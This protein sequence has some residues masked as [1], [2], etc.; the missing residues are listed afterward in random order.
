MYNESSAEE[1]SGEEIEARKESTG[2][3]FDFLHRAFGEQFE[4]PRAVA[5]HLT[6]PEFSYGNFL[7]YLKRLN[8][9]VCDIPIQEREFNDDEMHV[10]AKTPFG[11]STELVTP[12][13]EAQSRLLK[14][15]FDLMQEIPNAGDQPAVIG[16]TFYNAIERIHP[17]GD[18]NGRT[19][20]ALFFLLCHPRY[21]SF[22]DLKQ[23][24]IEAISYKKPS[25]LNEYHKQLIIPLYVH[26][27]EKRGIDATLNAGGIPN[28]ALL[29]G[30]GEGFGFDP[31]RLGFLAV[32][33]LMSQEQREKSA[34]YM[35]GSSTPYYVTRNLPQGIMEDY[36]GELEQQREEFTASIVRFSANG[37]WPG[38][39][40][41]ELSQ[42]CF[43]PMN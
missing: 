21:D 16:R 17:F 3:L 41:G 23:D 25:S 27:L 29:H 33:D 18:G 14:L 34:D 6:N 1:A 12:S 13:P 8:G 22:D 2:R 28:A 36:R 10:I 4:D 30:R 32:W 39:L 9:L 20:R 19:A 5:D 31:N 38:E 7:D 40:T 37:D 24:G 43:G 35:D 11:I 26:E 42:A 15:T